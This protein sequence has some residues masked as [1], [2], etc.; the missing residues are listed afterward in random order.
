[1]ERVPLLVVLLRFDQPKLSLD[2]S[3]VI[4]TISRIQSLVRPPTVCIIG[5]AS[6]AI[7]RIS[8]S[9]SMWG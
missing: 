4:F 1:M 9:V 8:P 3:L 5:N 2:K 6:K 7:A